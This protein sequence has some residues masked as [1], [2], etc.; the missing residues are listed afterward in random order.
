MLDMLKHMLLL[1]LNVI[2]QK[3]RFYVIVILF[4]DIV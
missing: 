3:F 4:L 1:M 2:F